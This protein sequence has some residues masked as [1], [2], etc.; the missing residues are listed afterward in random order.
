MHVALVPFCMFDACPLRV[1]EVSDVFRVFAFVGLIPHCGRCVPSGGSR[2]LGG[3]SR[4]SA[5]VADPFSE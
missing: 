4:I 1:P 5:L 3:E 2:G